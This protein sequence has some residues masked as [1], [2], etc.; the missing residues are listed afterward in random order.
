MTCRRALGSNE[1]HQGISGK[2]LG[3]KAPEMREGF[4]LGDWGVGGEDLQAP[5]QP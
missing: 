5:A 2:E 4:Q 1:N 3:I